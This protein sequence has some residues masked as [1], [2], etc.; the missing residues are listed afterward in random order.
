MISRTD[1]EIL[2]KIKSLC[3]SLHRDKHTADFSSKE[4]VL[5]LDSA[6]LITERLY[7][8]HLK[9]QAGFRISLRDRPELKAEI[10]DRTKQR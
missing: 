9:N 8:L 1:L 7:G 2:E 10:R 5:A 4:H 6:I 3:I